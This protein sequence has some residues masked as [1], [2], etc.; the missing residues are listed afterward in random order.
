MEEEGSSLAGLCLLVGTRT[1]PA[2][3]A[4]YSRWGSG[5]SAAASPAPRMGEDWPWPPEVQESPY[6]ERAN[7]AELG[8]TRW[9]GAR[10]GCRGG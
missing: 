10:D 1:L 8:A 7:G 2:G 5:D 4:T 6:L 9:C 3:P